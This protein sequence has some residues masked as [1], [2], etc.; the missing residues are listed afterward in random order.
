MIWAWTV[1]LDNNLVIVSPISMAKSFGSKNLH[2]SLATQSVLSFHT[3]ESFVLN[4]RTL[5]KKLKKIKGGYGS[6]FF[7][8]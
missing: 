8:F 7:F 4:Q 2:S 5:K 3:M 6:F 1:E